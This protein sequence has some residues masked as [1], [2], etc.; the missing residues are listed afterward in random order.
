M[1]NDSI[2]RDGRYVY[3]TDLQLLSGMVAPNS[4]PPELQ[5]I[6][7]P[8]SLDAWKHHLR[9]HPHGD[10]VQYLLS[11]I[12]K[13]F[14]IGFDYSQFSC[15]KGKCNILSATKNAAVV[16]DYLKKE[17]ALGRVLG[18]FKKDSLEVHI[19]HF[20][21]IPKPHQPGKWRLIVDLSDTSGGSVNDG[22]D[23]TLCSLSYKTVDDAVRVILQKGRDTLLTKLD[24]ENA[25]RVVPVH[26]VD[27][28]LLGME[29]KDQLYVDAALPL[30]LHSAPKT[31]NALANGLMWIMKHRGIKAVIYYLDDY[32]FFSNPSSRECVEALSLALQL[33]KCLGVPVSAHKLEGPAT[34]LTFLGILLDTLKFE[35][36]LPDDKL[37][38]LKTVLETKKVLHK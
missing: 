34:I 31:F 28:S 27:R 7:T 10:F 29:W 33:C 23:P 19:N 2:G 26:P 6:I 15:G 14:R 12:Q 3:S 37:S 1:T 32:L 36:S 35:I 18:L 38:R 22:V 17:F 21:V 9:S 8:L 4:A 16:E 11:G 5:G 20:G 25:Y 13:G 30:G 24:L